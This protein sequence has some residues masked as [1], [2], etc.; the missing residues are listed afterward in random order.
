[1]TQIEDSDWTGLHLNFKMNKKRVTEYTQARSCLWQLSRITVVPRSIQGYFWRLLWQY[2]LQAGMDILPD[3]EEIV[4]NSFKYY[5]YSFLTC[6]S[7]TAHVIDIGW[8]SVCLSITRC[9]CVEMA[10]PIV[11]QSSLPGSRMILVFWGPNFFPEFQ[12]EHPQW[13]R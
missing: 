12:W 9:Y 7:H 3:S 10:Q 5:F 8:T 11:K 13:G 4:S 1:M 6:V 2:L